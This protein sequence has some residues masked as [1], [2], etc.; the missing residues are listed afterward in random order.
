VYLFWEWGCLRVLRAW[1]CLGIIRLPPHGSR[2]LCDRTFMDP[3]TVLPASQVMGPV[4]AGGPRLSL[5]RSL[6]GRSCSGRGVF[7]RLMGGHIL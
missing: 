2:N 3:P 6:G 4:V 7:R 1:G 5:P